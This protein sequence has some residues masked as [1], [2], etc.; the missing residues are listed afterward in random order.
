MRL[1]CDGGV[2]A[3]YCY[4]MTFSHV[5][6]RVALKFKA[7]QACQTNEFFDRLHLLYSRW[8]PSITQ[9][10]STVY[11]APEAYDH[12]RRRDAVE[13]ALNAQDL[14]TLAQWDRLFARGP[15]IDRQI[16]GHDIVNTAV[17]LTCGNTRGTPIA[18]TM[19]PT[20][21]R[22]LAT[23]FGDSALKWMSCVGDRENF[24]PS[25]DEVKDSLLSPVSDTRSLSS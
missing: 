20:V 24:T 18:A 16:L 17:L 25:E 3:R 13:L 21:R 11:P 5:H 23:R 9:L 7:N 12:V 2:S 8:G 6:F 14:G 4:Q 1:A 22:I 15:L 19:S 10:A